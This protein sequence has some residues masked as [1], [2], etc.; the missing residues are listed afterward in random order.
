MTVNLTITPSSQVQP[1][2]TVYLY[3][4]VWTNDTF[5]AF[6]TLLQQNGSEVPAPIS[7]QKID[8]STILYYTRIENVVTSTCY[9]CKAVEWLGT[10]PP[11][12]MNA[13]V[14]VTST[15]DQSENT[16]LHAQCKHVGIILTMNVVYNTW[17]YIHADTHVES[18]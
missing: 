13:C 10:A 2:A 3:C 8:D 6:P 16:L 9:T 12:T 4:E 18:H 11:A 5:G 15:V 7:R 17:A 1:G 14:N